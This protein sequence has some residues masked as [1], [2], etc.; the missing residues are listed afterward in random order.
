MQF[1]FSR[2]YR[3][4]MWTEAAE[5]AFG[6]AHR[7]EC[8]TWRHQNLGDR[9]PCL[10]PKPGA[11]GRDE[12]I[13]RVLDVLDNADRP[14][15]AMEVAIEAGFHQSHKV[16]DALSWLTF[17]NRATKFSRK[18]TNYGQTYVRGPVA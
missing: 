16:R 12:K 9:M 4:S 3:S 1:D 6:E 18:P 8:A 14:L 11:V 15:T 17:A 5:E 2:A 7:A 10:G 13:A